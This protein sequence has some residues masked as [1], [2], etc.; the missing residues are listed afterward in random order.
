MYDDGPGSPRT[1][2]AGAPDI[3]GQL[4]LTILFV[5]TP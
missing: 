4:A 1:A 2:G 5:E 3:N